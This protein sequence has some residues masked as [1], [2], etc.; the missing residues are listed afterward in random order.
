VC[1]GEHNT[2]LVVYCVGPCVCRDQRQLVGSHGLR[3]FGEATYLRIVRIIGPTSLATAA[4]LLGE[5]EA[6][7]APIRCSVSA[8]YE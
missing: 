4:S 8:R 3:V 7:A 1:F 6:F 2:S 5:G